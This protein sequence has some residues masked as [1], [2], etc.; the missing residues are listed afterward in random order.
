MLKKM[1]PSGVFSFLYLKWLQF[2]LEDLLGEQTFSGGQSRYF[3]VVPIWPLEL[4]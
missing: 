1:Y 2:D 3:F 4:L